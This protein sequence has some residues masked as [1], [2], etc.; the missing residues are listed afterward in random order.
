MWD[1]IVHVENDSFEEEDDQSEFGT[2][3]L[4]NNGEFFMIQELNNRRSKI[5]A[6]HFKVLR[7]GTGNESL[8]QISVPNFLTND[9]DFAYDNLNRRLTG[10]GLYAEKNLDRAN[11]VFFVTLK[12]GETQAQTKFEPFDDKLISILRRKDVEDDNRGVADS[13]VAHLLPRQDGGLLLVVERNHEIQRGAAAGR[14]FWREGMRMV[15]DFYYDDLYLIALH[16]DGK[17]HWKT[18]LHK[19]QYSQDDDGIFS[20]YFLLRG[21]DRLRFI[22]NDE[23]KYE[24]TCSEYLISPLG[25]FDRNS[26][27]NTEGLNLRMRFRDGIQ[28][29][30]SECLI[31]SEFRNKLRLVKLNF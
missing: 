8:V 6:H 9:V 16:P 18:V 13:E 15:V 3:C 29:S 19:K 30:A 25:E 5:E 17:V 28:I 10:A 1:K 7:L 26:L 31:P 12:N 20:S 2:I 11:G 27:L 22:F 24:N 23:L 4:G 14:G 21:A